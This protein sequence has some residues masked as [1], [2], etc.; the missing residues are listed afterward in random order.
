VES[1]VIT[2]W[3]THEMKFQI[4]KGF[5]LIEILVTTVVILILLGISLAG[6]AS[7]NQRQI[8][9][10]A[11]QTM[12]NIIRDAQSRAYNNETDCGVCDC[13]VSASSN[14]VGWYV[15]FTT[16]QIYGQC[17]IGIETNTFS[18]NPS[19]VGKNFGLS[20]EILVTPYLTPPT[21][22]LFKSYP[23]S[24]SQPATICLSKSNL[25][26]FYYKIKVN[27]AGDISDEGI[28]ASCP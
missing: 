23:P 8:L 20:T 19:E 28:I 9:I 14:L 16:A 3:Q 18:P 12:K 15:D 11:G 4:S 10:S 17:K 22:L 1:I 27:E 13:S 24:V 2:K 7:F 21:Q 6:Y 5:T 26:G 25:S